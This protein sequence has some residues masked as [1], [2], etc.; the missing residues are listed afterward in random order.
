MCIIN[1]LDHYIRYMCAWLHVA[2]IMDT[3]KNVHNDQLQLH[4][5]SMSDTWYEHND[6]IWKCT[7]LSTPPSMFHRVH[8]MDTVKNVHHTTHSDGLH[9][10][11]TVDNMHHNFLWWTAHYGHHQPLLIHHTLWKVAEM[12][13]TTNCDTPHIIDTVEN[14]HHH[15]PW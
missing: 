15:T 3:I 10:M 4:T 11:D 1:T 7:H 9:I 2:H 6:F 13:I 5:Y 8:I 14:V 12:C